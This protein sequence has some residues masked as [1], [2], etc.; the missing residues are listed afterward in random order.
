MSCAGASRAFA[1]IAVLAT[2][3]G[4]GPPA[5]AATPA[6]ETAVRSADHPGFGRIVIDTNATTEYTLEQEGD[7]VVVHLQNNI[8]LGAP[9]PRPRNVV[10][11][12]IEGSTIDLMLQPGARLR[13]SRVGG[14]V[15]LDMVDDGSATATPGPSKPLRDPR[16]HRSLSMASSPELGGR[17]SV[18]SAPPSA[19]P[20]PAAPIPA[21]STPAAP[22]PAAPMPVEAR[23]LSPPPAAQQAAPHGVGE[24]T[25]PTPPGRDVLPENEGPVGL[26]ARRTRLPK[27]MDGTAFLV[28]FG[29]TTGAA[30]FQSGDST[31]VVFDE[32]RPVDMAA[33]TADPV[34]GPASVQLLPTGTLLRIPHPAALSIALTQLQQGWRIA[35]LA[36]T[37]KQEPIVTSVA[38]GRINL[39]AEQPSD[40]VNI[41]DPDTGATLLVGT[42]H[43]PG[44]GVRLGR[45]SSEFILRPTSQGVVVEALSDAIALKPTPTGFSLSGPA[46]GLALSPPTGTTAELIDAAHL[47][48]RLNFS[49]MPADSLRRL[50]IAQFDDAASSPPLSRGPKHRAAAETFLALGLSAEAESLLHMASDQDPKE[51]ASADTEALS[52]IAALLAGRPDESA[53]LMDPKLNGTDEI[54][55]WRAVRQAMQDEGS[56]RAA[57]VFATT[58]PLVFQYPDPIREHILPLIAETMILGGEI[59]P[60]AILLRS[61]KDDPKLAYARALLS[62]AE[63]KSDQALTMLDRLANGHDQF[64]R[65]RAAVRAV[66]LRLVAGVLN[67]TQAADALDKLLYAWRGDARE[68]ALRERVAELR[69]QTGGWRVALSILRQAAI[70]FPDQTAPVGDRLKDTFAAMIRDQD[71]RPT[72]PIEFVAM[73]EEN[74]DLVRDS[75]DNEAVEQPLADRLLALDLPGRAKPVFDKLMN[76]AKSPVAKAR[77]GASLATLDSREG[78]DAGAIAALDASQGSDLPPDLDEQRLILRAGSIARQGDPAGAAAMLASTRTA[79]ATEARAQILETASDWAGAEQAW[80]DCVAMTLPDSGML[81]EP[82]TRTMLRLATAA[83]RAGH[84][85]RL[86][87]LRDTYG[88]RIGPG[89][90]GD[91]FRLL[92]VEPI[93]TSTDIERSQREMS[94]AASLPADLKALQPGGA[95]R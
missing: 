36:S 38:D 73:L 87:M 14:R 25:E 24:L 70:D 86:G 50:A 20:P 46:A 17:S 52:A 84:D 31:Y 53:G 29:T 56:P 65:A 4:G 76:Q 55:L 43:R 23:P 26:R 66:E 18:V 91:M 90:L 13:S 34:F 67:K 39:A 3:G 49:T 83:A 89:P 15:I 64:D 71:A 19:A 54:E 95:T 9:P 28:P 94:L 74:T 30:A 75:S 5:G 41:A 7:H 72:P 12:T 33:L 58:A 92:T 22:M 11:I 77:F 61:R 78:D 51:A 45:H 47:T 79:R 8:P 62:N 60:A 16:P 68:L 48:R 32:R 2:L 85:A 81:D 6:T 88:T 59:K 27:E 57:A 93:R 1:A 10:G 44:Q 37:P 42:Q 35:A 69:G 82:Q 40:V 21:A 80:S 63:G